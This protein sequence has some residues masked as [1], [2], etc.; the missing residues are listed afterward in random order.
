M[1]KLILENIEG[2]EIWPII[3]LAIFITIFAGVVIWA[4]RMD[5]ATVRHLENLPLEPDQEE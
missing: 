5:P 4:Y 1:Y 2:I 3:A